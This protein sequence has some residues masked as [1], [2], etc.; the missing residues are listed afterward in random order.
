MTRARIIVFALANIGGLVG[1]LEPAYGQA[2]AARPDGA[3]AR[4][5]LLPPERRIPNDELDVRLVPNVVLTA[6]MLGVAALLEASKREWEGDLSCPDQPLTTR[7]TR[8]SCDARTVNALDRWAAGLAVKGAATA[9]DVLLGLSLAG[10][11]VFAAVDLGVERRSPP[12]DRLGKDA[13][14]IAQT[15]AATYLFTTAFKV[16]VR[17]LRPFNYDARFV[18]AREDGD[19]RLSFPSGHASMAFASAATLSV[20]LEMRYSGEAWVWGAG[21]GAFGL[22]STVAIL[23][24]VAGRHFPTDVLLGAALGTALGFLIPRF[25]R[26]S[27]PPSSVD[28]GSVSGFGPGGRL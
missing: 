4:T 13:L 16:L 10:P 19:S 1:P 27:G 20:L 5:V 17:R 2:T 26:G 15:Y 7:V 9:S 21:F 8:E 11:L 12:L 25:H 28:L 23:R 22:A 6:A 3:S 18:E 24:V 14:V